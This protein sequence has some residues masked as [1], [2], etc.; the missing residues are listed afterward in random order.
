MAVENTGA[1]E[2]VLLAASVD[3][4]EDTQIHEMVMSGD[5]MKMRAILDGIPIAAGAT[6]RLE[7][8]GLHLMLMRPK[9]ALMMGSK[10]NVT[11]QFRN[12]GTVTL[13]FTVA[14]LKDIRALSEGDGHG[15]HDHG[16]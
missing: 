8:G 11:L 15:G 13:P 16:N 4:A 3:I 10:Y 1:G 9:H 6:V 2:E 14:P 5:V 12:A 7:P